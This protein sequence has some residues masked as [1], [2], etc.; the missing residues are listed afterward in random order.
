M[1]GK[2]LKYELRASSRIL[3]PLFICTL[4]L[5]VFIS[6]GFGFFG[7]TYF[8]DE[9]EFPNTFALVGELVV[10]LLTVA[11]FILLLVSAVAVFVIMVRRF[12]ISFFTD[13]AY[14]TF[15]L[16]VTVDCHIMTKTVATVIWYACYAVVAAVSVLIV[17][18]GMSLGID[19]SV[20]SDAS[21][22]FESLGAQLAEIFGGSL[23]FMAIN[24]IIASFASLF[25]IYFSISF[26]CMVAKKH[27]FIACLLAY[28]VISGVVSFINNI[29]MMVTM[30]PLAANLNDVELVFTVTTLVSTLIAAAELAGCYIGTR[31]I[32]KKNVNLP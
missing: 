16:P 30:L 1:F 28:F 3:I 22:I 21:Y 18:F 10:S 14:L 8:S 20:S 27:R 11:F 26:G 6:A 7:N 25:L 29:G 17:V 5:S 15:T 2:S 32:L 9:N 4:A 24:Y 19:V 12:Y 23:I 13:E 31:L